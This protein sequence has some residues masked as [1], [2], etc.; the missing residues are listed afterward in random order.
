MEDY[1]YEYA[2]SKYHIPDQLIHKLPMSDLFHM[3]AGTSTGS[4]VTGSLTMPNKEGGNKFNSTDIVDVF[5]K[6]GSVVFTK[7]ISK[8]R[9]IICWVVF[10]LI[11]FLLGYFIGN[12]LFDTTATVEKIERF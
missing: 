8:T 10:I 2:H 12:C 6:E 1:A 4:L 11:G 9:L 5:V 7:P 3:M